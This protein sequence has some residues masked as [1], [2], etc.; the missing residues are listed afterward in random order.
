MHSNI[1]GFM[2]VLECCRY[3][4]VDGLIYASSSSVYGG[5]K[6]IPFS[7]SDNVDNPI[8]IYVAS[9]KANELMAH[10]YNHLFN[11][12]STGLRF[13]TVYGPWVA[14]MAIY[15][16]AD[17]ILKNLPIQVFNY[18]KM[19]RDFTFIDDIIEGLISSIENNYDC[20]VFNLG[21]N[22]SE[23]LM[24]VVGIIEKNREKAIVHFEDLQPGDVE[25]TYADIQ[26]A[27]DKLGFNP[28]TNVE[29]GIS[30]FIDWYMEYKEVLK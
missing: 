12:N 11:L 7:E 2:N 28:S 24:N 30:S 6:K 3:Y 27:K 4:N 29:E 26:R 13:F 23:D 1:L 5:N 17:R 21:N 15:I 8:S 19:M 16:F 14:D 10:S 22:K 9:K 18:G 25:K 20:E